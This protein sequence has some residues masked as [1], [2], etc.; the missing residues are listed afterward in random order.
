MLIVTNLISLLTFLTFQPFHHF[1]YNSKHSKCY[2]PGTVL[3]ALNILPPLNSPNNPMKCVPFSVWRTSFRMSLWISVLL[4][5]PLFLIL[6]TL[7][8]KKIFFLLARSMEVLKTHE[9]IWDVSESRSG[10]ERKDRMLG[11]HQSLDTGL[12]SRPTRGGAQGTT[13][14]RARA[15][16]VEFMLKGSW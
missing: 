3:S 16:A 12:M 13:R 10:K 14:P 9:S 11:E 2:V 1:L 6:L 7:F 15:E 8:K 4:S 5:V